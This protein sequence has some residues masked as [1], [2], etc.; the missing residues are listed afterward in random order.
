MTDRTRSRHRLRAR[1]TASIAVLAALVALACLTG[2]GRDPAAGKTEVI[3]W[4]GWSGHELAVQ[5]KLVDEFNRTHP[6][7]YVRILSQFGNSGYQKVRIAFAGG[8][9]PDVMS[10][11]W[12][13][14]LAGYAMRDVLTP[15]DPYLQRAGRDIDREYTPGVGRM[16][17]IGGK[18]YAMAVTTNTN[19]IAY[20]RRIFREAGLDPERPPRTITELDAA[21]KA[22]TKYDA[23]G[24]FV[25]Y[26]FRPGGLMLWAY[27]FGGQWY[28]PVIGRVTANDPHNVAALKWLASYNQTYDLRKMQ[29]FQ[30]TFGSDQTANGPFFV[31]KVAMWSTG[32]W[33]EEYVKRYAPTLDWGWFAL[34]SPPGGRPGSTSAGG[35]VFVIPAACEHKEEAWEFL[36]WITSPGPV[37]AF[38]RSIGNVPPLVAVGKDPVFQNDP[39]FRFAVAIA[40]GQNSFGPPPIPTWPTFTREITRVEE[41]AMLGGG[42]PQALLDD[43]QTRMQ[44]DLERTLF[45]LGRPAPR[46]PGLAPPPAATARSP[47]G[48]RAVE[49]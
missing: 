22:C 25:R 17:R 41:K 21:A 28:D 36:N 8:A 14:E 47:R 43:L 16:L 39:L 9:T 33:A 7:I 11:V 6:R 26:G 38:C 13:D 30:T 45:E 34:P 44:R 35:S 37:R 29:A 23:D 10:T 5:A 32:E 19:F 12:A 2:C 49:G 42:D 1:G 4:T 15:L 24:N 27:I 48:A 40:Q 31:G 3:Y 18:C 46:G 20:S